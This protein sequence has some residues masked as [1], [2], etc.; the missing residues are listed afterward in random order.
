[1]GTPKTTFSTVLKRLRYQPPLPPEIFLVSEK[2]SGQAR[3]VRQAGPEK[4]LCIAKR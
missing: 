2:V 3:M 4:R 1:M